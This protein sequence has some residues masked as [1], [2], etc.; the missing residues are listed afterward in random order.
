MRVFLAGLSDTLQSQIG[1]SDW[2]VMTNCVHTGMLMSQS[3]VWGLQKVIAVGG[4]NCIV[5]K[6]WSM[7]VLK[8]KMVVNEAEYSFYIG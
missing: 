3:D 4:K 1:D 8:L 2:L 5:L 6:Q 7:L